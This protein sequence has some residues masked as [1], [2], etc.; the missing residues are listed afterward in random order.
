PLIAT[1]MGRRRNPSAIS[2]A[3][4]TWAGDSLEWVMQ[5]CT[6]TTKGGL[7]WAPVRAAMVLAHI[8]DKTNAVAFNTCLREI[9]NDSVVSSELTMAR[10]TARFLRASDPPSGNQG[11]IYISAVVLQGF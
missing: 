6:Q 3:V 1:E 9:L 7:N 10:V 5:S 11:G 8:L 4:E 2:R